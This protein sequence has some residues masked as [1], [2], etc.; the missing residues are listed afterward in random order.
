[1]TDRING[2]WVA[3][4]ED[5]RIDDAEPIISAVLQLRHVIDV[6]PNVRDPGDWIA[7]TRARQELIEKLYR[8]LNPKDKA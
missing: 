2:F 3:L 4:D 1:M 7:E 5:I 8:V 6:E